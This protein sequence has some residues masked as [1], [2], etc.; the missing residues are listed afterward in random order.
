[1]RGEVN[2]V[3]APVLC[4]DLPGPKA[5]FRMNTFLHL[6]F[7]RSDLHNF[8]QVIRVGHSLGLLHVAM[9]KATATAGIFSRSSGLV[10]H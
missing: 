1:M 2:A 9:C 3:M 6:H 10:I 4:P 8:Q 5:C 7:C